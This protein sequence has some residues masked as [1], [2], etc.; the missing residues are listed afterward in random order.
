MKDITSDYGISLPIITFTVD[1]EEYYSR[2][3]H[4]K[5]GQY[6]Q[7]SCSIILCFAPA[8]HMYVG[9][10]TGAFENDVDLVLCII[11]SE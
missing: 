5:W 10:L 9:S 11:V 1:I 3:Y 2:C 4:G 8:N 7:K 6:L